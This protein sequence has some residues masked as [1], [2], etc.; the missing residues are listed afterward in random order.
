MDKITN[1]E[2]IIKDNENQIANLTQSLSSTKS[3]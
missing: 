1:L 3:S 2:T